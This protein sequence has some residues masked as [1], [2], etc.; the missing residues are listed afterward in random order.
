MRSLDIEYCYSTVYVHL[1]EHFYPSERAIQTLLNS[2]SP[3]LFTES[4]G[5]RR[6]IT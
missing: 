2:F 6:D 3:F 1:A 5:L 4:L